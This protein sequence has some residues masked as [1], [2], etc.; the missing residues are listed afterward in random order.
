MSHQNLFSLILLFILVTRAE[1]TVNRFRILEDESTVDVYH[2]LEGGGEYNTFIKFLKETKVG[3]RINYKANSSDGVTVLA[4]TDNAF[5]NLINSISDDEHKLQQLI[6]YH[7]ISKFYEFDEL[8][9]VHNP[10]ETLATGEDNEPLGLNFTGK[11]NQLNVSSGYVVTNVYEKAISIST[12]P[13][14][15]V[16]KLDKVLVPSEFIDPKSPS[17]NDAPAPAKAKNGTSDD[18]EITADD[19][20]SPITAAATKPNDAKRINV[21]ILCLISCVFLM[22]QLS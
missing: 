16:Y 14:L 5:K 21:G 2:I 15:A 9:T 17:S 1:S 7:V 20:P 19:K 13:P 12:D 10:V 4:P 6:N 3:D 8:Q 22:G 11:K 18:D